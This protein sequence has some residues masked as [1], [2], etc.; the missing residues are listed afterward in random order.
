MKRM[1]KRIFAGVTC[2]QIVY[3]V[4]EQSKGKNPPKHRFKD[5]EERAK[6]RK[7]IALR[8]CIRLVN[9]NCTTGGYFAT[10]TMDDA[11]ECHTFEEARRE[12]TCFRRRLLHKCPDAIL[13]I[14][15]GRG[16]ST[17]RIH[18]HI[19]CDK[20]TEKDISEAWKAGSVTKISH[21]REH[22][23]DRNGEDWGADFTA[24]TTYCFNHWTPEQ[25][26]HYYSCTRNL[27]Q[28]EE[29]KPTVCV[30]EYDAARPPIAPKGYKMVDYKDTPYGYQIWHYVKIPTKKTSGRKKDAATAPPEKRKRKKT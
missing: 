16:N 11:H 18:L 26:G 22:N 15:M 27:R 7:A 4:Q 29:E 10:L 30:R 23:R 19:I 21:L 28:P 3:S 9:E 8:H 25:G 20:V 1:K 24:L 2:D 17:S 13:F 14:F 12:R 5:E 6:H